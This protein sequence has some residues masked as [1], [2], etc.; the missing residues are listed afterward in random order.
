[1]THANAGAA[2][3]SD[4]LGAEMNA[5]G[6]PGARA[7]PAGFLEKIDRPHGIDV[8]AE[9]LFVLGFAEMSMK[10]AIV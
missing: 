5:M 9:A 6:E 8:E 1:M 10:L 4:L 7:H 2:E 3:A